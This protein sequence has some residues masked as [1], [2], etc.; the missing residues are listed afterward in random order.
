[1]RRNCV[2][3]SHEGY[4]RARSSSTSSLIVVTIRL[5][6]GHLTQRGARGAIGLAIGALA[7]GH[8]A[9]R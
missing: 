8:M 6:V 5:C 7:V 9:K 2:L 4:A 1:M 3:T